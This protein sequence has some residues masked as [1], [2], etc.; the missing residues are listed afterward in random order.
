MTTPEEDE[1]WRLIVDHYD[2]TAVREPRESGEQVDSDS[3]P[4]D[5]QE[6]RPDDPTVDEVLPPAS[7][8]LPTP[9][10]FPADAPAAPDAEDGATWRDPDDDDAFVPP[11]APP[12]P[13]LPTGRLVAW[14]GVLGTP[15]LFFLAALTG[16]TIP[17]ALAALLAGVLAAS[18]VY[19][20]VSQPR[21]PRDPWDD[22]SRV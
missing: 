10:P 2:E 9:A 15:L 5:L 8:P 12:A 1:A 19:L 6:T 21:D 13:D 11:P 17:G 4:R 14:T 22:G 16:R 3:E 7:G 18:F 20:V